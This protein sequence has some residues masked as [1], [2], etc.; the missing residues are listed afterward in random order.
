MTAPV[1]S[2]ARLRAF[3]FGLAALSACGTDRPPP[4]LGSSGGGEPGLDRQLR[5][6]ASDPPADGVQVPTGAALSVEFDGVLARETLGLP[7]T[8][9]FDAAT[10][11]RIAARI[12]PA[13]DGRT[14]RFV[15]DAPLAEETDH[16]IR[17]DPLT[18]D[19]EGRVLDRETVLRFRTVDHRPPEVVE[20]SYR[21]GPHPLGPDH[22]LRIR[23]DESLDP[24]TVSADTVT[25]HDGRGSPIAADLELHGAELRCI[26]VRDLGGPRDFIAAVRG[27][28]DRSGNRMVGSF[29]LRDRTPADTSPPRLVAAWP[30]EGATVAPGAAP[31]LVF[32]E[33]VVVRTSGSGFRWLLDDGTK[34][35]FEVR[36]SRD[37]RTLH[38]LPEVPLPVGARARIE[39]AAERGWLS[40]VSG[41]SLAEEIALAMVVGDDS[42]PPGLLASL[43][44]DGARS[45]P[46]YVEPELLFDEPLDPGSVDASRL[47]LIGPDG[48]AVALRA[49]RLDPGGTRVVLSPAEPLVGGA[50]HVLELRSG[51]DG[52]RDEAGNPLPA[53]L[54]LGFEVHLDG[55]EPEFGVLPTDGSVGVPLDS[56]VVWLAS[57]PLDPATVDAARIRVVDEAGLAVPGALQ[58]LRGGRAVRFVP[59]RPWT[60]GARY[61][62]QLSGTADGVRALG[63]NWPRAGRE[64]SFRAGY[65]TDDAPPRLA[66]GIAGIH[67]E[68]SASR[69][70][71][72][73]GFVLEVRAADGRDPS[74]DPASVEL[75]LEAQGLVLHAAAIE[76]DAEPADGVL[77]YRVGGAEPL[78]LGPVTARATGRDLSGNPADPAQLDFTVAEASDPVLPFERTQVVWVRFDLDRDGNQRADFDDDLLR[79]GLLAEGD[80]LGANERVA[81]IVRGGVL[82]RCR[83]LFGRAP[84]GAPVDADSVQIRLT[85][86]EPRG[87]PHMQIACGGFDPE[88]ARGRGPGDPSTGTLGRAWYDY[89]NAVPNE[90]NTSVQPGLGVFPAELW[91]FEV[92]THDQLYPSFLTA[93]ARSF[94]PLCPALGGTA[95]GH[96]ALDPQALAPGFDPARAASAALARWNAIFGAADD[97]ATVVGTILAHEV[98]HSVGLTA[99]GSGSQGLHGDATLHNLGA[100]AT[101]VMAPAIGFEALTSLEFRFRDLNAAYLR[102]QVLL[103]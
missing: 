74:F 22:P 7:G 83:A 82:A 57:V 31:R 91:L 60:P 50:A 88:G 102:Q 54:E 32:D 87:I 49:V 36:A 65:R 79:L 66:I 47:A 97:W 64:T 59:D 46:P 37:A 78:P 73:A 96:H 92:R 43:P 15:P 69:C 85:D 67:G 71:P 80:P 98:G 5:V 61:A 42:R 90:Q 53:D 19:L 51:L 81:A 84:N 18:G 86:R 72:P 77:R 93:F 68:R 101:D 76:R 44:A 41:N 75:M 56:A 6:L 17:L 33:S 10:G 26:P 100:N 52:I 25:L 89:R 12:E 40:D 30:A 103:R 3:A 4:N 63:G 62:P 94:L 38:L 55:R 45:V 70:V 14:A 99:P 16:Q 13:E 1:R 35:D 21:A 11:D 48:A 58:L 8:G 20:T 2:K 95:A 29:A 24:A 34:V 27:L 39:L 28:A 23:F 9:L